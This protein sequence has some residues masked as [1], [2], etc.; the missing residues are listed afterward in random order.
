MRSRLSTGTRAYVLANFSS[1]GHVTSSAGGRR[2]TSRWTSPA[3]RGS[4]CNVHERSAAFRRTWNARFDKYSRCI[5]RAMRERTSCPRMCTEPRTGSRGVALRSSVVTYAAVRKD[6]WN[7][8]STTRVISGDRTRTDQHAAIP[9][10][11]SAQRRA[12]LRRAP[13]LHFAH[14]PWPRSAAH[15]ALTPCHRCARPQVLARVHATP[16]AVPTMMARRNPSQSSTI[17]APSPTAPH[18]TDH[19]RAYNHVNRFCVAHRGI[20]APGT[21]NY[22]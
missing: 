15:A 14:C 16:A 7:A 19:H 3:A 17:V 5:S 9:R 2:S 13:D 12:G 1:S 8:R 18:A 10:T 21:S 11:L 4:E 22:R 6:M 20:A